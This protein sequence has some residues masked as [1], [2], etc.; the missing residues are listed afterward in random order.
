MNE[1]QLKE[2]SLDQ[3]LRRRLYAIQIEKIDNT[4]LHAGSPMYYYCQHC[5]IPTEVLP[6]EHLFPPNNMCSQCAVL[7][8]R[9]WLQEAIVY[10]EENS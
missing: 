5:G 7:I 1:T 2:K 10:G 3:F 6:E 4:G 8:E 9:N